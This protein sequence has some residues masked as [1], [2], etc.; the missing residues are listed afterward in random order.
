MLLNNRLEAALQHTLRRSDLF[1][2]ASELAVV[3]G[4]GY[5]TSFDS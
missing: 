5:L 4:R 2:A 1:L 3:G